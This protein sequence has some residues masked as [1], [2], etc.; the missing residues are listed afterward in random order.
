MT[1][2]SNDVIVLKAVMS[3]EDFSINHRS[4]FEEM[5]RELGDP[6]RLRLPVDLEKLREEVAEEGLKKLIDSTIQYCERYTESVAAYKEL[7][8]DPLKRQSRPSAAR[9]D[10][11]RRPRRNRRCDQHPRARAQESGLRHAL[12][13]FFQIKS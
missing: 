11:T 3:I 1:R 10:G 2:R 7:L 5:E 13:R 6:E 8:A 12:D 4:T 9:Y